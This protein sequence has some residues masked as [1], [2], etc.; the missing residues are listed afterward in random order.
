MVHQKIFE[1]EQSLN[2]STPAD[3]RFVDTIKEQLHAKAVSMWLEPWVVDNWAGQ[4]F[5]INASWSD[6][7]EIHKQSITSFEH[8]RELLFETASQTFNQK[9][10]MEQTEQPKPKQT[11]TK[12]IISFLIANGI[13]AFWGYLF[14]CLFSLTWNPLEF[15]RWVKMFFAITE[16]L[17]TIYSGVIL[18]HEIKK[19][20]RGLA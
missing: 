7:T 2:D 10:I 15:G 4:I 14:C 5:H 13:I 1:M 6:G 8:V 20:R 11:V 19:I 12:E 9:N 3:D 16:T 17:F 18:Y